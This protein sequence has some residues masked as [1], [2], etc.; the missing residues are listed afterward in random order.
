MTRVSASD[1]GGQTPRKELDAVPRSPILPLIAHE[2]SMR[3]IIPRALPPANLPSIQHS[4]AIASSLAEKAS[5]A[6]PV[7]PNHRSRCGAMPD[8]S[9]VCVPSPPS[10][11]ELASLRE[12]LHAQFARLITGSDRIPLVTLAKRVP[13]FTSCASHPTYDNSVDFYAATLTSL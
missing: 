2:L 9:E 5:K 4:Q 11:E 6:G 12:H 8:E 3:E 1:A 13:S 7:A 10:V